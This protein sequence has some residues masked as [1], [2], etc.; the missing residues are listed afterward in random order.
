MPRN[1]FLTKKRLIQRFGNGITNQFLIASPAS[2]HQTW[3]E[4]HA[5]SQTA[6]RFISLKLAIFPAQGF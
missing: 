5:A 2:A 1:E 4:S 3:N 6:A